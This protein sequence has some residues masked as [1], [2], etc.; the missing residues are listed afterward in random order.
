LLGLVTLYHILGRDIIRYLLGLL[1]ICNFRVWCLKHWTMPLSVELRKNL[2]IDRA[3][4]LLP[5]PSPINCAIPWRKILVRIL[6]LIY[7][8][9]VW[10]RLMLKY[11]AGTILIH[12]WRWKISPQIYNFLSYRL[13]SLTADGVRIQELIF[14]ACDSWILDALLLE[15][16][17][18]GMTHAC[19]C[20]EKSLEFWT[21]S[22][23]ENIYTVS[24][25]TAGNIFLIHK[26][27]V[28]VHSLEVPRIRDLSI[29]G[30]WL[31]LT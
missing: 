18:R 4:Q 26:I 25:T 20:R 29:D 7:S 3:I 9:I 5:H 17:T 22:R 13:W 24:L 2:H 14:E 19:R 23:F 6:L 12:Y 15:G 27:V 1:I 8:I 28:W 11:W 31:L 21:V 10:L 30:N 16:G